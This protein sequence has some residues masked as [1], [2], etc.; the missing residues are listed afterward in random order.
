MFKVEGLKFGEMLRYVEV[1]FLFVLLFASTI[2][3][4]Q[5]EQVGFVFSQSEKN[6]IPSTLISQRNIRTTELQPMQMADMK[7]KS[8]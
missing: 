1:S 2:G 5:S 8:I 6:P 4:A 3:F 7:S